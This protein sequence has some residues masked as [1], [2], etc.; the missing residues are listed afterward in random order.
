MIP[1]AAFEAVIDDS[2]AAPR[3]EV[4]LPAGVRWRQ[5]AVRTLLGVIADWKDGPHRLT[6]RPWHSWPGSM[7]AAPPWA[8][9]APTPT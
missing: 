8:P 7:T 5:L 6:C 4:M 2:G 1:L 3:I 9:A